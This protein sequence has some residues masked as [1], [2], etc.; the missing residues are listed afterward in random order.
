MRDVVAQGLEIG[1]ARLAD[2][3]FDH[4]ADAP[5]RDAGAKW[6]DR[7]GNK[8]GKDV[9][10]TILQ[11]SLLIDRDRTGEFDEALR[12]TAAGFD[13]TIGFEVSGPWPPYSFVRLRL[14]SAGAAA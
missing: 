2:P 3:C 5:G 13:A 1:D 11:T 9:D 14:S 12:Q 8:G 6:L 7:S 10:K 4:R